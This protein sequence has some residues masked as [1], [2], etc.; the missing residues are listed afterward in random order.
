MFYGI[1][2]G[3]A[4]GLVA[5]LAAWVVAGA[6]GSAR[7]AAAEGA[8]EQLRA[9]HSKAAADFDKLREEFRATGEARVRAETELS[10][11]AKNLE[12]QRRLLA[13]A[14]KR[15]TDAFKALSA[16][17]L[18]SSNAQ[19]LS[20]AEEKFKPLRDLL[21][22]YEEQ[23]RAIEQTRQKAY[24]SLTEQLRALGAETGK[25]ATAL[26]RPGARGKWGELTL[27]R[28]VELA[29][30]SGH[31]DFDEQVTVRMKDGSAIR[32]DMVISMP[33]GRTVVVDSKVPLDA[34]L[35]AVESSDEKARAAN[36]DRHAKQVR[37]HMKALSL[38]SY[39]EGFR[40]SPEFVV[41]FIP[42]ESFLA[43]AADRDRDLIEDGM[44]SRVVLATPTTLVALLKAVAFGWRQE[45]LAKNAEEI[46]RNARE[47]YERMRVFLE[48]VGG[49]G[50]NLG[51]AV[52]SYNKAVGS[53]QSRVLP[54]LRRLEALAVATGDKGPDLEPVDEA[55]RKLEAPEGE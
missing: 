39:W 42:G 44:E 53:A 30:M 2:I 10:E 3:L 48:H 23:V 12:E 29:G 33:A 13:E 51:R 40:D 35:E 34:Y 52:D 54:Q 22:R 37:E 9:D 31:C 41:M 11:A 38:K 45:S 27:R 4:V 6:R 7:A 47:L 5:A 16:D 26:S 55:P 49:V 17:A 28:T 25:L 20:L 1:L 14:E 19:F 50:K 32:P 8:L 15:L 43:A 46:S 18:K 21:G 24:G 36:L